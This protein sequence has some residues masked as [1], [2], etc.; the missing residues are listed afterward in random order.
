MENL[1]GKAKDCAGLSDSEESPPRREPGAGCNIL[2]QYWAPL[3]LLVLQITF[4]GGLEPS[5]LLSFKWEVTH[6]P[7]SHIGGLGSLVP[8]C[9]GVCEVTE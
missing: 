6:P 3:M 1:W 9:V 5:L 4:T 7:P 8:L 2:P